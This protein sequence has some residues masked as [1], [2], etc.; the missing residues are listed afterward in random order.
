VIPDPRDY[1]GP[2]IVEIVAY[3]RPA[4]QGSKRHVGNGRMVEQSKYVKPFRAAITQAAREATGATWTPLDGP[5]TVGI[6][7]TIKRP[8]KP[9]WPEPATPADLDKLIRSAFD[10]LSPVYKGKA[11]NRITVWP[12][13]WV[14]DSRVT[15]LVHTVKTYPSF[16]VPGALQSEGIVIW[17]WKGIN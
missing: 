13:V 8:Q 2:P 9:S 5:L 16:T 14:D 1:L 15:R 10:S 11:P 4:G 12:G 7:F 6:T 3:A 17:I